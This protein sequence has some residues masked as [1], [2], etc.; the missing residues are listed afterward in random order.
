[1]KIGID[2]RL[3]NETGV[4]RYI[5]NLVKQIQ[6]VD[7]NNEY[8]L[9]ARSR[10]AESIKDQVS[11]IKFKIVKT[12]IKWHSLKE[13]LLFPQILNTEN[14][15]LMHFTYFSL[16]AFYNRPFVVTIHD[17]IIN[18]FPTGRASTLPLPL[19]KFKHLG[20]RI[21]LNLVSRKARKIIVPLIS[22]KD[23]LV[24]SLKITPDK[25]VVTYE[26]VDE[27][28]AKGPTS[29][30]LRGASKGQRVKGYDEFGKYFLYVGNAYPH[31]NLET[32]IQAFMGL[33]NETKLL[34]VGKEDYFYKR[35]ALKIQ[36]ANVKNIEILHN[37]DDSSLHELYKNAI[38]VVAPSLM[39]GFGLVPLEA[40]ANRCLVLVSDIPSHKE[41][42]SDCA[43]YFDPNSI[44]SLANLLGKVS[45]INFKHKS[46]YIDMGIKR[47][48]EFSW[49]KMAERT[50][51][52]YEQFA[53]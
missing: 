31:K 47:I 42:C 25:I 11:N 16:P 7:K 32:L 23:D 49:E 26:G 17:L 20:Y 36:D 9:F 10:D 29:L 39:E 50:L 40:M 19:Y 12:D 13:Q 27:V 35:L 44:D 37:V 3:W 43:L 8:V 51:K 33:D 45:D 28:L 30:K 6:I 38:A 53:S 14:L 21:I 15:D 4:G 18:H 24:K 2:V 5:R 34:L 41:V 22:T 46:K 52:I 48:N 1:M